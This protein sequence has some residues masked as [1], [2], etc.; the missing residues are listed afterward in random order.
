MNIRERLHTIPDLILAKRLLTIT[1][2]ELDEY[3]KSLNSFVENFPVEEAEIK[4][5]M[6]ARDIDSVMKRLMGI[7][8]TLSSIYADEL[9]DECWKH[10]N[11]LDRS[12][13]HKIE[14]YVSFFLSTL[15]SLSI[16]IQMAF[17]KE[18]ANTTPEQTN[19][20][21]EK[22]T[23]KNILA[24]DDD[25]YFLDTFKAALK[26]V[27]CKIIG[28]TSGSVALYMLTKLKPDLFVLDIE[29]PEMNGIELAEELRK[30]GQNAPIIFI[31][32]SATKKY[33]QKCLQV[34]ASDFIVKPINPQYV[35]NRIKKFL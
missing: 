21:N 29:M 27:S 19:E 33:V 1:D 8:E 35:V 10:L 9:A 11:S 24:I 3:V 30:A 32:G 15:T 28:A 18:E 6:V 16:D 20:S 23:I 2:F 13:P 22:N 25:P 31:T 7:R 26:D 5:A 12:K 14:A 17:F 4:A 34:G